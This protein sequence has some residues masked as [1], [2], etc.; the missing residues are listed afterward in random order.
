MRLLGSVRLLTATGV[1]PFFGWLPLKGDSRPYLINAPEGLSYD[2]YFKSYR[3][4]FWAHEP[5]TQPVFSTLRG[6]LKNAF[7]S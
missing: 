4:L 1:L 2:V 7:C 3:I 5:T 6:Y